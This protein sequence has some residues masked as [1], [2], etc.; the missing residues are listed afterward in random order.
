MATGANERVTTVP[1]KMAEHWRVAMFTLGNLYLAN[2]RTMSAHGGLSPVELLIYVTVGNG[3]VQKLM[4]EREIPTRYA[5]TAVLPRDLVIPISRNA[6]ATATGLPRETVRRQVAKMIERGLFYED[7]RG[8]VTLPVGVID[9]F[10]LAPMLDTLLTN[11]ARAAQTL[12]RCGVIE[13][14]Q[15]RSGLGDPI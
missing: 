15:R 12:A 11:F 6:I 7:P 9:D 14:E 13:I 10:D 1:A 4:R 8:G 3:N 5:A 2:H